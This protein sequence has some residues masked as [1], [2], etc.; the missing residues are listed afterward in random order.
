MMQSKFAVNKEEKEDDV[1]LSEEDKQ[2]NPNQ[3]AVKGLNTTTTNDHVE[4][5]AQLEHQL[6]LLEDYYSLG[7]FAFFMT[8][9]D[10][11]EEI[12]FQ[13]KMR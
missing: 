6:T 8:D 4:K 10:V 5:T 3:S 12:D 2:E 11:K 1:D 13:L 9:K 7:I